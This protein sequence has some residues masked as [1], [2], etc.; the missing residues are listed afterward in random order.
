MKVVALVSGGKDSCYN[1]IQCLRYGHE[2]VALANL[3]PPITGADGEDTQEEMDSYMY[4]TVGHGVLS[5]Y[6]ECMGVPLYREPIRGTAVQQDL[7]Y[8]VDAEDEVESTFRLLGRIKIA[9]PDIKAVSSGAILSEYQRDRVENICRRLDLVSLGY[10]WRLP[11]S[12]LFQ[13]MIDCPIHAVLI[14]V[15]AMGLFPRKHLGKTLAE[16]QPTLEDLSVKY[17]C[18]VCGEGGEYE[19]MT[20]DCPL[21]K[22]RIVLDEVETVIHS[23]DIYAPVGYL[24]IKR[25]HVV[26]KENHIALTP[27]LRPPPPSS[28]PSPSSSS[29][30]SPP[31]SSPPSSSPSPSSSSSPSPSSVSSSDGEQLPS[32][33]PLLPHTSSGSHVF[34]PAFAIEP[35][36]GDSSVSAQTNRLLLSLK[37]SLTHAG[38][39]VADVYYV[40]FFLREMSEF[41]AANGVYKCHFPLDINPPSRTCIEIKDFSQMM[42]TAGA[43]GDGVRV[44]IA[45]AAYTGPRTAMHVES[46]SRWAPA[47]I[48]PYSQ[49][50]TVGSVVFLAGNIALD[51]PTMTMITP[52][53]ANDDDTHG[54]E[55]G[56]RAESELVMNHIEAVL[57]ANRAALDLIVD[58][59]V[60][61][62]DRRHCAAVLEVWRRRTGN[63]SSFHPTPRFVC[64]SFLPRAARVEIAVRAVVRGSKIHC[65]MDTVSEDGISIRQVCARSGGDGGDDDDDND[66]LLLRVTSVSTTSTTNV[67]GPNMSILTNGL[68]DLLP[69]SAPASTA[70]MRSLFHPSSCS[71]AAAAP[72]LGC[73]EPSNGRYNMVPD[74]GSDTISIEFCHF[75]F[76]HTS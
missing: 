17:G 64:V 25:F 43:R 21:F 7:H 9:H 31:P 71:T 69:S 47:S 26:D 75:G 23:D 5:A 40:W 44:A 1:M 72:V 66:R 27:T 39:T 28:S 24:K 22:K 11:Q 45:C 29:S 19:T 33:L 13:E 30:P 6:S 18:N 41:G 70:C 2:V 49:A 65:T 36:E 51:P 52:T 54:V 63:E 35:S 34:F 56:I 12:S 50:T 42:A 55:N 46:I 38:I 58:G 4:Q 53:P 48:G 74:I 76:S 68:E 20:L 67:L 15:A 32:D 37:A 8:T 61:V 16:M 59:V 73:G 62:T 14:K 10:M 3:H 57:E 60:Y